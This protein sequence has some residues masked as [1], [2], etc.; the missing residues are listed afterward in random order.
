MFRLE[1]V[2]EDQKRVLPQLYE[3]EKLAINGKDE[4][5]ERALLEKETIVLPEQESSEQNI[6]KEQKL[7]ANKDKWEKFE[8]RHF[9]I[10][11]SNRLRNDLVTSTN[12]SIPINN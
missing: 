7:K 9:K 1:I 12:L 5:G 4:N 2:L 3:I 10:V 6:A 8:E 11:S